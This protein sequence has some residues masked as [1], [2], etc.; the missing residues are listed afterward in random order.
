[1]ALRGYN[2][3]VMESNFRKRSNVIQLG[4]IRASVNGN[5][6]TFKTKYLTLM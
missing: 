3:E 4:L 5:M 1:M 6:I 2:N